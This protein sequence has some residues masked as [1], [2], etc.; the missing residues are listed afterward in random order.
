[1]KRY[2]LVLT[3][4]FIF[5][6][7]NEIYSFYYDGQDD[8]KI[9]FE[10]KPRISARE[11][12]MRGPTYE[13][14]YD[15]INYK[16]VQN[17]DV[18]NKT[19]IAS[20]YITVES[21]VNNL[22]KISFDFY[23]MTIDGIYRN[24]ISLTYSVN[25]QDE[26]I[27]INL[28][29]TFNIGEKFTI[30]IDYHGRPVDGVSFSGNYIFSS[31]EPDGS[32]YWFPC[33]DDPS[34]KADTS[35]TIITVPDNYYVASNGK[36]IEV[37]QNQSEGIKTYHW[38]ES[39]PIAT[40]LISIACYPYIIVDGQYH[41]MPCL[42]YVDPTMKD[43]AIVSLQHQDDMLECYY[44]RFGIEFPFIDEKYANAGVPMSGGMENQTCTAMG[45]IFFNGYNNYDWIFA[46][47]SAHSWWGDSIT[48]GTWKDIWLNEGFATYCDALFAEWFSGW[49]AF[50]KRMQSFK[51]AY[52]SEDA[53]H[54]YSIYDPEDMWNAT[55]YEKG[56]WVLHMLRHVMG[57]DKFF[58]MMH[59]Y[60]ETYK[61]KTAITSEFEEKAREHY[62]SDLDWFFTEWVYKAGYPEYEWDWWQESAESMSAGKI[63][64]HVVQ[65]QKIDDKTPL[66][67]MPIDFKLIKENGDE[68]VVLWNDQKDQEFVIDYSEKVSEIQFDPNGW[69]LC[70][71]RKG[72]GIELESFVLNEVDGGVKISW[73]VLNDMGGYFNLYKRVI[74]STSDDVERIKL[75]ENVDDIW[76]K[77]NK[78]PIIGKGDYFYIDRD[79]KEGIKYEYKIEYVSNEETEDIGDGIIDYKGTPQSFYVSYA[80]PNPFSNEVNF[81]IGVNTT[82]RVVAK[83]YDIT[84]RFVSMVL[85]DVMPAGKHTLTWDG[86]TMDGN[87]IN[88]GQYFIVFSFGDENTV[89][90]IIFERY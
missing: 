77:L 86:R 81:D 50:Y 48:C 1:L 69:L 3:S 56:A 8:Y 67:K 44:E 39:H 10:S 22:N 59:D 79:V 78:S 85:D 31:T 90:N 28:D 30:Q 46:H 42:G 29:K 87:Y 24:G 89:K 5:I 18:T 33:Y 21:E 63:H 34:D 73:R 16:L 60:G 75:S 68:T 6:F 32:H 62:G 38:F 49:D 12:A 27:T 74:K 80:Y 19:I 88:N 55:V 13:H 40:Y 17:I 2:Y 83:V 82:G 61:Y 15:V 54:R 11:L 51:Q 70:K 41:G 65:V 7:A 53:K 36:L 4:I 64:I 84:G 45:N 35:E 72:V 58:S 23:G 37:L 14:N 9:L 71:M 25:T 26:Y 43:K 76:T 57:D 52:F 47:E 20:T 66:F